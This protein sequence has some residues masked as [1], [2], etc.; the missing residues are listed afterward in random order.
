MKDNW[1][2]DI[3]ETVVLG[4]VGERARESYEK[5]RRQMQIRKR[6]NEVATLRK[7]IH[8]H[9]DALAF[10]KGIGKYEGLVQGILFFSMIFD[11]SLWKFFLLIGFSGVFEAVKSAGKNYAK[12]KI[13]QKE[14]EISLIEA[15]IRQSESILQDGVVGP[16]GAYVEAN[17]VE[18]EK[19]MEEEEVQQT[20]SRRP[21]IA[22]AVKGYQ[23]LNEMED[24]CIELTNR[25]HSLGQLFNNAYTSAYKV[26][27]LIYEKPDLENRA[28]RFFANVNTLHGW[29]EDLVELQ[30]KGV[31]DT[32]LVNVR[33]KA[34]KAL[35][36]LQ[37]KFDDEYL[38]LVS[39][40][41]RDLEAEMDVMSK[42]VY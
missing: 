37:R 3:V 33:D 19:E 13:R 25:D 28:Y 35:P 34:T 36:V 42:E 40:T 17:V 32:L 11:F 20:G 41:L 8:G 31:Y 23:Q 38:R 21:L 39:P 14:D 10:W 6:Q 15:E 7:E 27:E 12:R 22:E 9:Q 30:K 24:L 4:S 16:S 29:A 18:S 1:V 26:G 5:N 2:K